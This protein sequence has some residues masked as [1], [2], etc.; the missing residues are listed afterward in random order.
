MAL[1]DYEA[2]LRE[3]LSQFDPS[4]DISPGS[5]VDRKVIQPVLARIGSDPFNTNLPVFIRETLAQQF[6]QM[7]MEE[8]G[9]LVDILVKAGE[10]IVDPL[11]RE[12]NRIALSQSLRDKDL[13]TSD[14]AAALGANYFVN[15]PSG[16]KSHGTVRVI[17]LSLLGLPYLLLIIFGATMV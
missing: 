16:A 13:L 12:I 3:K 2:F 10:L 5:P 14:E 6:P 1:V 17:F 7:S 9:A 8:G 15:L 11:F 4:L